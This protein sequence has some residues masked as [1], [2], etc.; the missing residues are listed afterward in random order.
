MVAAFLDMDN[1]QSIAAAAVDASAELTPERGIRRAWEPVRDGCYQAATAYLAAED[2]FDTVQTPAAAAAYEQVTRQLVAATQTLDEFYRTHR[3]HLEESTAML[4]AVPQVAQ[5]A[6]QVASAAQHRVQTEGAAYAGYPSVRDRG[7]ALDAAVVALQGARGANP[8]RA[9]AARVREEAA[10]LEK[11]LAAA[12]SK[13][14]DAAHA[15]SSVS[16]RIAA[17]QTRAERLAPAYSALLREF[18]AASSADLVHNDRESRTHIEQAQT[19]LQQAQKALT[20]GN[21]EGALDLT[22]AARTHL[23]D[24]EANVDGVTDRLLL[25]REVR[26]NPRSKENEIRFRLRDAQMLAVNRG[27]VR[28]WGSVLDAQLE[29]IDRIAGTLTGRHPD[30]W[31]YVTQLDAVSAFIAEVVQKMRGHTAQR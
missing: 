8:V 28:E 1:R 4:A 22:A 23:V 14:R 21:P 3:G 30:Y 6:L 26:E 18:N 31:A 13:E 20:A 16:T 9:S 25:L 19:D 12:P 29:R 5:Q 24:A 27:L 15:V 2:R 17:V 10:A 11:A 7:A